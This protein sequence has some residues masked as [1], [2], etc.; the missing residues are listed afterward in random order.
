M[1]VRGIVGFGIG[2][3]EESAGDETDGGQRSENRG[4]VFAHGRARIGQNPPAVG[5]LE[6]IGELTDLVGGLANARGDAIRLFP[7]KASG[8]FFGGAL[9]IANVCRSLG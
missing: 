4:R 8:G 6:V 7:L 5:P 1:R 3:L 9:N 2:C